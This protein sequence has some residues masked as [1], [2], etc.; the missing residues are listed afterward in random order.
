MM[1]MIIRRRRRRFPCLPC[2][3]DTNDISTDRQPIGTK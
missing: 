1:M 2:A 3:N